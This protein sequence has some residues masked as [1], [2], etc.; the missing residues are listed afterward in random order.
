MAEPRRWY[1]ITYDIRDAKRWRK[2][3][4]LLKGYGEWL[5]LSVFR[6]SLTDRD[7]EKL[8]WELSR[9]MDP[10]DTLLVIGLCG[11]CVERVRAINPKEDWPEEQPPFRVL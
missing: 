4:E 9:R 2:V 1:L 7:R 3:Y 10:V 8:R 5:Q 11:G 6:C